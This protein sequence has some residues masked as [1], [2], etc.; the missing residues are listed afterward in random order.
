MNPLLGPAGTQGEE[1]TRET[2]R[3]RQGVVAAAEAKRRALEEAS[4]AEAARGVA[5][6]RQRE[7]EDHLASVEGI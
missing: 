2:E 1:A 3:L 5:R 4:A 7:A 6:S